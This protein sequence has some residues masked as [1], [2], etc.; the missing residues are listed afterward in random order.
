MSPN[1]KPLPH[2]RPRCSLLVM[3]LSGCLLQLWSAAICA[4]NAALPAAPAAEHASVELPSFTPGLWEYRRT[5][6]TTQPLNSPPVIIRKCADPST[7]MREKK[8]ALK[9]K[10]CQF[11]PLK[12]D[13]NRYAS[14]WT[15]PTPQGL[16]KFRSVVT[17]R[18]STGYEDL[19]ETESAQGVTRQSIE[20]TRVG[21]CPAGGGAP[22]P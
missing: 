21:E 8:E 12:R 1:G 13:A 2:A 9:K 17:V 14:S 16:V 4:Q 22:R 10:G 15:C 7:E 20:A 11:E 19:S 6:K 18:N 5:Q 3:G